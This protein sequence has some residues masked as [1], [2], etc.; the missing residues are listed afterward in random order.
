M[1]GAIALFVIPT[2]IFV[3]AFLYETF[4]AFRRVLRPVADARRGYITATWE[5]THTLLVFAV[6]MLVMLF[7]QAL[8]RLADA[9]FLSTFLAAT[10]LGVRAAAYLYIF[11]VRRTNALQWVDWLFALSHLVA[12]FFLV[13]TVVKALWFVY[14]ERPPVNEQFIPFFIPGLVVVLA[15]CSVPALVLYRARS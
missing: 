11:Y 14:S 4:L 8:D 12:A 3:V 15:L 5:V 2:L 9:L 13:V 7:T 1:V 10:A 6:I